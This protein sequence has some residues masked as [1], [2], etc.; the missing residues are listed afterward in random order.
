MALLNYALEHVLALVP[1]SI[2]RWIE[3]TASPSL[4]TGGNTFSKPSI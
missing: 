4:V 2:T 1:L 3:I